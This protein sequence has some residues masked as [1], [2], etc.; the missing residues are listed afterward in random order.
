M[1]SLRRVPAVPD[2]EG[3]SGQIRS[4]SPVEDASDA[5][6]KH[7]F[8]SR[9][10]PGH[11]HH[12]EPISQSHASPVVA[13]PA[14]SHPQAVYTTP[15]YAPHDALRYSYSETSSPISPNSPLTP[16]R[17]KRRQT[18]TSSSPSEEGNIALPDNGKCP[19]CGVEPRLKSELKK[20]MLRHIRPFRCKLEG[21]ESAHTGFT[22]TNDLDRHNRSVHGIFPPN[23]KIYICAA[24]NCG[25]GQK[26]WPRYDNFKQHCERMH[27]GEDLTKLVVFSERS[28]PP[29]P[30]EVQAALRAQEQRHAAQAAQAAQAPPFDRRQAPPIV[31]HTPPP[32]PPS[33]RQAPPEGK[34][35]VAHAQSPNVPISAAKRASIEKPSFSSPHNN[36]RRSPRIVS[37]DG[38]DDRNYDRSSPPPRRV[39][40]SRDASEAP[41]EAPLS[42]PSDDESVGDHVKQEVST[43][44]HGN[45]VVKDEDVTGSANRAKRVTI[46]MLIA[47]LAVVYAL[48]RSFA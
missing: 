38:A 9:E 29:P 2:G 26:V 24:K 43:R 6:Q 16:L 39:Q 35:Y 19:Y 33:V 31:R 10:S 40:E 4:P 18:F 11:A 48:S 15:G 13:A 14:R 7:Q 12:R 17:Q 46:G 42:V 3:R 47:I 21:C 23:A 44:P 41:D 36:V 5:W 22:T 27:K 30:P 20:H 1:S 8:S 32:P 28:A 37:Y 25:E 34:Y 45:S